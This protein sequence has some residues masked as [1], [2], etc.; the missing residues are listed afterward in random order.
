MMVGD[1]CGKGVEEAA[2]GVELRVAWRALTIAGVPEEQVLTAL[3]QMLVTERPT[4][5][6]FVTM[7]TVTVDLAEA[8]ATVRL[9]GHPPPLLIHDK[10]GATTA[11]ATFAP[12]LGVFKE[13]KRPATTVRLDGN[14]SLLLYTDGLIDGRT[15]D[16]GRLDV[17][18]LLALINSPEAA[19][20]PQ[21][22]LASWLVRRAEEA[23][24]GPLADD[25]A[26]L[27]VSRAG[28]VQR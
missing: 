2:L 18:G 28:V 6:I 8:T 22:E 10:G 4:A 26:M 24:A 25:V 3:E 5:D 19:A 21:G 12:V 9:A 16:G 1:V 13:S 7:A 23:N 27:L 20:V 14:W 17:P 15:P 11:P